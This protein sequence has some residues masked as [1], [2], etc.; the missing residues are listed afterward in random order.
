MFRVGIFLW[1]FSAVLAE[2]TA[3]LLSDGS[4]QP[5]TLITGH[6]GTSTE[7]HPATESCAVG[8]VEVYS[9]SY[10][11]NSCV[12]AS[13]YSTCGD[14]GLNDRSFCSYDYTG[15]PIC[16]QNQYC[17]EI[18]RTCSSH[19]NCDSDQACAIAACSSNYYCYKRC[20]SLLPY[21]LY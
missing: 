14:R 9:P 4:Q 2:E 8:E 19:A 10:Y 17:S 6:E 3:F 13:Q 20:V 7:S 16:L 15:A 5:M 18:T 21:L 11:C 12:G 1:V